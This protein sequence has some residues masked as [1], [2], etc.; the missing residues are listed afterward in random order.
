MILSLQ[1]KFGCSHDYIL[2][3]ESWTNLQMKI[4]DAPRISTK[5]DEVKPIETEEELEAF[6]KKHA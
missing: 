4:A 1:E 6:L 3:G 2:W 5:K